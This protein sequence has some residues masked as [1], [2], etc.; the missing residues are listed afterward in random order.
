[1][2]SQKSSK[3]SKSEANMSKLNI[4]VPMYSG[5][6]LAKKSTKSFI[7]RSVTGLKRYTT[8][9]YADESPKVEKYK[10]QNSIRMK[11]PKLLKKIN[12]NPIEAL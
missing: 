7:S 2:R 11:S 9:N 6:K 10:S 12:M 1:M 8:K 3:N 4:Y 5:N